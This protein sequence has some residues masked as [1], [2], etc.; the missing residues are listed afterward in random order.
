VGA[1]FVGPKFSNGRRRCG[2]RRN[3][4]PK[5]ACCE[6]ESMEPIETSSVGA[7]FR[8]T[9]VAELGGGE[10]RFPLQLLISFSF[11]C[12]VLFLKLCVLESTR[13]STGS[14]VSR[15]CCNES[16]KGRERGRAVNVVGRNA[17]VKVVS[18]TPC[19]ATSSETNN[20]FRKVC[21]R[22]AIFAELFCAIWPSDSVLR[23]LSRLIV[24]MVPN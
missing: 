7:R 5:G 15:A 18:L 14:V 3:V 16:P 9:D 13:K 17:M 4:K 8:Y 1:R 2:R 21:P 20:A 23:A 12:S 10:S 6:E 22:L 24:S 11:L 19:Q